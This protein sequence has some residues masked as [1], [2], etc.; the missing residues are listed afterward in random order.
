MSSDDELFGL[1]A[2]RDMADRHHCRIA[3]TINS[4]LVTEK[5]ANTDLYRGGLM[6][7]SKRRREILG[8][9]AGS[10]RGNIGLTAVLVATQQISHLAPIARASSARVL[11]TVADRLG[12]GDLCV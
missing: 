4:V 11:G 7:L 6:R 5:H 9:A 8:R 3:E 2:D 10:I 12:K 1:A